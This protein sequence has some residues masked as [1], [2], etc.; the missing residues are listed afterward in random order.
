MM[1]SAHFSLQNHIVPALQ[2]HVLQ[3]VIVFSSVDEKSLYK[4]SILAEQ[5]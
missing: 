4:L 5:H 2:V 1:F 3:P